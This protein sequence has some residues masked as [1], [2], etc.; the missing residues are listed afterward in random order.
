MEKRMKLTPTSA[1]AALLLLAAG[2]AT[3]DPCGMV[4]PLWSVNVPNAI[5]RVG[6]QKT[7]VFYEDGIESFVLRP[8][9]SGKVDEF[10]MLISFPTPP[11]MRKVP[12]EIFTQIASAIDPPTIQI[13]TY[14]MSPRRMALMGA[15]A[16]ANYADEEKLSYSTVNV[17][18]EEAI[19]MY[20]MAVLEAGSSEALKKWMEQHQY[21]YPEGMD[22]AVDDYVKLRWCFVAVKAHVGKLAGVEAKPGMRNVDA[23]LPEGA[24]FD[25]AV[26]AMEYRFK[27]KE[28]VVPMRLSAYNDGEPHN[29][30]YLLTAGP[31]RIARMPESFVKRQLKGEDLFEN[32]TSPLPVTIVGPIS[33]LT[34]AIWEAAQPGR[35]PTPYNGEAKELFASDVLSSKRKRLVHPHEEREKVYL[36]IAEELNMRGAEIDQLNHEAI[37]AESD[38]ELLGTLKGIKSMTMTVIDAVLPREQLAKENLT[39]TDFEMPAEKN[40]A[41][42]YD[43]NQMGPAQPTGGSNFRWRPAKTVAPQI[44]H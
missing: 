18:R 31:K 30:I 5:T 16:S 1:S 27:T 20:E 40:K 3:A 41:S 13:Y 11:A 37:K 8:A 34:K 35:D 28:L 4:P 7:Y 17:I 44:W 23:K 39:F 36:R 21:R 6:A 25:G 43:A 12:E 24:T 9:F 29:V 10:G 22:K 2:E 32:V 33:Q 19:G 15:G 38:E 14:S 42:I 26:H